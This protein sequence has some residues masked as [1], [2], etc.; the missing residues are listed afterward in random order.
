MP[1]VLITPTQFRDPDAHYFADLKAAGF[2]LCFPP[3]ED[4]ASDPQGLLKILDGIDCVIASTEPYTAEVLEQANLRVVA[5]T[6]VGYD[7]VDVAAATRS[8]VVVTIT[9][10]AVDASVAEHTLALIL[11]LYRDVPGRDREVRSGQWSRKGLPRL[12]GKTLGIVGLG[13]IG[14]HVAQLAQGLQVN[15][16]AHDPFAGEQHAQQ[17]CIRLC[18]LD[19]LLI[20]ADIVSLHLPCTEKTRHMINERTLRRMKPDA[21]L[22]NTGRGG[23]V[24]ESALVEAI[25]RGHLFGAA[26]DVF[27]QEPLPLDSPLLALPNV[28]LSTHTAGLDE[29]SEID[30]P[31]IA[32]ECVVKLYRGEWPEGCVINRELRDGW[33]WTR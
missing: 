5:R 6:G 7:S 13:R 10:G 4:H 9:P 12:A 33:R 29:Q 19:D 30:M 18:D 14:R 15:V 8:D 23:L 1:R 21:V 11:A 32:A 16:V 26:L 25:S 17:H 28:V 20:Q 2:E 24:D 31:R 22:V 27:A 3:G